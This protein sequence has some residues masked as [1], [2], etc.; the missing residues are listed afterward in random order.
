[1][2]FCMRIFVHVVVFHVVGTTKALIWLRNLV[3]LICLRIVGGS[4]GIPLSSGF[5]SLIPPIY[6]Y[7]YIR[8]CECV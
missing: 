5:H 8:M 3:F 1:M 7:T 4:F 6:T 2:V